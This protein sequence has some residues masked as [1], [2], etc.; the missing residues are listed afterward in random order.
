MRANG[1]GIFAANCNTWWGSI[2]ADCKQCLREAR[3]KADQCR[4]QQRENEFQKESTNQL[5]DRAGKIMMWLLIAIGS[6]AF[7]NWYFK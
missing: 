4:R 6:I 2:G 7:L 5:F 1:G 3:A